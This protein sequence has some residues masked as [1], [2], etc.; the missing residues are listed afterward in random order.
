LDGVPYD[1][2]LS[3]AWFKRPLLDDQAG[4]TKRRWN[5]HRTGVHE[6]WE[7]LDAE[8]H[9]LSER[10][11]HAL[12]SSGFEIIGVLPATSEDAE[13]DLGFVRFA[14]TSTGWS[15]YGNEPQPPGGWQG[16]ETKWIDAYFHSLRPLLAE[17]PLRYHLLHR[18]VS[19]P[20]Y[21]FIYVSPKEGRCTQLR[22]AWM[23]LLYPMFPDLTEAYSKIELRPRLNAKSISSHSDD[24]IYIVAN[25]QPD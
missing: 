3:L 12:V 10:L 11:E 9:S 20:G 6:K 5:T 22:A 24:K 15:P 8:V 14:S 7:P 21:Q 1:R 18:Y 13:V 17:E 25:T 16:A 19:R 23:V 4:L 2:L